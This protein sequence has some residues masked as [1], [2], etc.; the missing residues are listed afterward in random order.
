MFW[1][2]L[3]RGNSSIKKMKNDQK[4]KKSTFFRKNGQKNGQIKINGQK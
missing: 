3:K 2:F 4:V 1:I